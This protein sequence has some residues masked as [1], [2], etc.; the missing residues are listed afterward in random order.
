M[1]ISI[2]PPYTDAGDG[3]ARARLYHSKSGLAQWCKS[4]NELSVKTL[5]SLGNAHSAQD[6]VAAGDMADGLHEHIEELLESAIEYRADYASAITALK[7]TYS[8]HGFPPIGSRADMALRAYES[9]AELERIAPNAGKAAV[10]ET[11]QLLQKCVAAYDSQI[12]QLEKQLA[13]C[14]TIRTAM[15]AKSLAYAD[16]L[17]PPAYFDL[18]EKALDA[19]VAIPKLDRVSVA[20]HFQAE[21]NKAIQQDN[22]G[23][24]AAA[25]RAAD[26]ARR[27]AKRVAH[28]AWEMAS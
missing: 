8:D 9:A 13:R 27:D 14:K 4:V 17:D 1:K 11:I 3:L 5:R 12:P 6:A 7:G 28:E 22:A 20:K 18:R 16:E 10:Q 26:Q 19:G 24:D 21:V 15:W 2:H 23:R 25:K